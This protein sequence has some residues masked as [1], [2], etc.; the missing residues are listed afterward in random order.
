M[1]SRP[2]SRN[3]S[4]AQMERV[5]TVT[6]SP[7]HA[8]VSEYSPQ[9]RQRLVFNALRCA[10]PTKGELT[11]FMLDGNAA[12]MRIASQGSRTKIPYMHL[13]LRKTSATPQIRKRERN[14]L[15]NA[16][17]DCAETRRLDENGLALMRQT[18][19]GFAAKYHL[20]CRLSVA[21]ASA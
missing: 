14:S 12:R 19:R 9:Y 5:H 18:L 15:E 20:R 2:R 17:A 1:P 6:E 16:A 7:M 4:N 21:A 8:L 11:G 10:L 3:G 13:M